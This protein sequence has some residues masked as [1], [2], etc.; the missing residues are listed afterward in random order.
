MAA[1]FAGSPC[2]GPR[3]LPLAG[4]PRSRPGT[5][6]GPEASGGEARRIG[7]R[8]RPGRVSLAASAA[9]CPLSLRRAGQGMLPRLPGACR[10]TGWRC[11]RPGD[12]ARTR[13]PPR[14]ARQP[15]RRRP[16]ARTTAAPRPEPGRW[17][18]ASRLRTSPHLR[19][20]GPA[21]YRHTRPHCRD[22]MSMSLKRTRARTP[23]AIEYCFTGSTCIQSGSPPEGL[24]RALPAHSPGPGVPF[25]TGIRNGTRTGWRCGMAGGSPGALVPGPRRPAARREA[26]PR[27]TRLSEPDRIRGELPAVIAA[28][29]PGHAA[30]SS[31]CLSSDRLALPTTR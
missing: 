1:G 16:A 26:P 13:R 10:A 19:A 14:P 12:A 5:G 6:P 11:R 24:F 29:R 18:H 2:T 22:H 23:T 31:G 4:K 9:G 28:S 25:L 15:G 7:C 3:C 17:P 30:T 21:A 20:H 27:P 8:S